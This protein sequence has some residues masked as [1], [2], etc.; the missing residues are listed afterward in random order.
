LTGL[1]ANST[2]QYQMQSFCNSANTDS[3]GYTPVY[4]FTTLNTG[5][6]SVTPTS[7]TVNN[8]TA[9][10]AKLNWGEVGG[11]WGYK[12]R[13]RPSN[14]SAPYIEYTVQSPTLF[15]TVTGLSA[16]TSYKWNVMTL[17]DAGGS[18]SSNWSTTSYFST[19]GSGRLA[20]QDVS[21]SFDVNLFPNPTT[22]LLSCIIMSEN[23]ANVQIRLFDVMGRLM[24]EQSI[25]TNT[26]VHQHNIDITQLPAGMYLLNIRKE[27]ELLTYKIKKE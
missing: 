23:S 17:C 3:S 9:S 2:Y 13:I 6:C 18:N 27:N 5:G 7:L 14:N 12:V 10:S 26:D 21:Y 20:E 1:T 16:N 8:I 19:L 15:Y 22:G 25:Y 11:A 24:L 4:T